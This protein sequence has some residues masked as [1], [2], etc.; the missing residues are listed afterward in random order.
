MVIVGKAQ[1]IVDTA[2]NEN[3]NG[4]FRPLGFALQHARGSTRK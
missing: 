1:A 3:L 4:L 2:G